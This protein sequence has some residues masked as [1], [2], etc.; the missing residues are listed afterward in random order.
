M[1]MCSTA[2]PA[3]GTP[4]PPTKAQR[5]QHA[6]AAHHS[7]TAL[8]L[9]RKSTPRAPCAAAP[10]TS[11]QE[12]GH[13]RVER[14]RSTWY[15]TGA[16]AGRAHQLAGKWAAAGRTAGAWQAAKGSMVHARRRQRAHAAGHLSTEK[17]AGRQ[18]AEQGATHGGADGRSGT[19]HGRLRRSLNYLH[20]AAGVAR[21]WENSGAMLARRRWPARSQAPGQRWRGEAAALE[22]DS[23]GRPFA[24]APC[25]TPSR[26]ATEVSGAAGGQ[27][28][29]QGVQAQGDGREQRAFA[30]ER[31]PDQNFVAASTRCMPQRGARPGVEL[32]STGNSTG[33]P[34]ALHG[35]HD[36]CDGP[37]RPAGGTWARQEPCR[38]LPPMQVSTAGS[39]SGE[40]CGTVTGV[41]QLGRYI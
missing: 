39:I 3:A 31:G 19:L 10:T 14:W 41:A 34:T 30:P 29:R 32:M 8:F 21:R 7:K 33:K 35:A 38:V 15:S 5:G 11:V 23:R 26:P 40:G 12:V 6:A 1:Q 17:Q 27:E 13:D 16:A 37:S 20:V 4:R 28:G 36:R 2:S 18:A 9:D 25:P 24:R 22:R